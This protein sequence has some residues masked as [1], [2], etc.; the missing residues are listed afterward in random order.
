M[1]SGY[2][3]VE[4]GGCVGNFQIVKL[5]GEFDLNE[6]NY[7]EEKLEEFLEEG[8][9]NIVLDMSQLEY[10]DSSGIGCIVR[11]YRDTEEKLNGKLIIYQP[12]DFIRELFQI[13]NLT[14]F[15][16]I[17]DSPEELKRIT[18]EK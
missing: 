4:D 12:K 2:L 8:Q 1:H 18:S 13:S 6:V 3:T 16:D 10:L 5:N 14:S 15:L 7:F 9:K 11:L 17:V